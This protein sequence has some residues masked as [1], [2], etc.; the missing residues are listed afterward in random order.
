MLAITPNNIENPAKPLNAP[1]G[2]NIPFDVIY[3]LKLTHTVQ[4]TDR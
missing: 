4:T 1:R 2:G 3:L